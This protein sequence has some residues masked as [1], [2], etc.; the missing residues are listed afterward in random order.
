[1][2][3]RQF[4][5]EFAAKKGFNP[6]SAENWYSVNRKDILKKR[7]K[8]LADV[9]LRAYELIY[10]VKGG[11]TILKLCSNLPEA[12]T[13]SFP[14]LKLDSTRFQRSPSIH[15]IIYFISIY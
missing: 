15:F 4:F 11:I 13:Q 6:L 5:E 8:Y 9:F 1:M 10:F 12:L 7:V 2:N 3:R 14:E